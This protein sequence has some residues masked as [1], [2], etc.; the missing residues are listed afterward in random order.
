VKYN[1]R[2]MLHSL[3]LQEEETSTLMVDSEEQDEEEAWVEVKV[4]SFFITTYKQAIWQGTTIILLPLVGAHKCPIFIHLSLHHSPHFIT[5]LTFHDI[6]SINMLGFHLIVLHFIH[7][8]IKREF[9]I[10][11]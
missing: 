5:P 11:C 4:K 1:M 2:E 10:K 9:V 6:I 8:S 7:F 3:I